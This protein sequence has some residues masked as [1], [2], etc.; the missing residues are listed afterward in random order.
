MK[1]TEYSDQMLRCLVHIIGRAAMPP[2]KVFEL[3]GRGEKLSDAFNLCD[4]SLNQKEICEKTGIDAGNLSRS[5]T[6][7][8]ES[9]IAFSIG[10]GKSAKLLHIYPLPASVKAKP[11]KNKKR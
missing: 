4:G 2:E 11:K 5:F 7:W 10:E 6:K 9:G 8:I 3:V 1:T